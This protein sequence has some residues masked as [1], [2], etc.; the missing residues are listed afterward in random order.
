MLLVLI[1]FHLYK[2][3]FTKPSF[4][5]EVLFIKNEIHK[6]GIGLLL[7]TIVLM[8]IQWFTEAIKW[9][10]LMSGSY[11]LSFLASLKM[12]FSGL[13]FSFITPF[14]S[15]EFIGRIMYLPE[16][17]RVIGTVYTFYSSVI[18]F[19][20]Y[21]SL[22]AISCWLFDYAHVVRGS[23]ISMMEGFLFLKSISGLVLLIGLIFM[24]SQKFIIRKLFSLGFL[25]KFSA[26]TNEFLS[27]QWQQTFIVVILTI[28]K[29]FIFILQYW[30]IFQ[31]IGLGLTFN[32]VF[33]GVSI[34]VFG[35]AIM[36]TISFIEIGLRWEFSY[37]IFSFFTE[38]LLAVTIGTTLIWSL[39]ILL[40]SVIGALLIFV[41]KPFSMSNKK[42]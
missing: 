5:A 2:E 39:N 3:L 17:K 9:K 35:L 21:I 24:F 6:S 25:K 41:K 15:G 14:K 36:P 1:G 23:S 40:P 42:G 34:M 30:L 13:T 38:N 20:I 33:M 31:W 7:I 19:I 8:V 37:F 12:I 22:G 32:Q 26:Y 4:D 18:Q 28:I 10:V 29:C 16:E 11:P 27:I